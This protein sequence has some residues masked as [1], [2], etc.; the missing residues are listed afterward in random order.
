MAFGTK[1]A[2]FVVTRVVIAV[3]LSASSCTARRKF[4]RIGH[5]AF[6]AWSFTARPVDN[7]LSQRYSLKSLCCSLWLHDCIWPLV[8][9]LCLQKRRVAHLRRLD[10]GEMRLLV[11]R[12]DILAADIAEI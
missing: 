4:A 5:L 8:W 10:G 2:C 12:T 1:T 3:S 9:L 6:T 11:G 7:R